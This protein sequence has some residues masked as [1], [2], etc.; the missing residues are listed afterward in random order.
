MKTAIEN[1]RRELHQVLELQ[2]TL[3]LQYVFEESQELGPEDI[4][5]RDLNQ[6]AYPQN[7]KLYHRILGALGALVAV[8]DTSANFP[9]IVNL[10][11]I[12]PKTNDLIN[13]QVCGGIDLGTTNSCVSVFRN[14]QLEVLHNLLNGTYE[15]GEAAVER[16]SIDS[17][18]TVYDIKRMLGKTY[19][20][21]VLISKYWSFK[22]VDS[23]EYE[24]EES[25]L[26][27]V[28]LF[29]NGKEHNYRQIFP[30]SKG[31]NKAAMKM[32]GLTALELISEP[33]AAAFA[34]GFDKRK[35]NVSAVEVIGSHFK[36]LGH[37]GDPNLGGRDFDNA[38]FNLCVTKLKETCN[39]DCFEGKN[40]Q[41][42]MQECESI[43]IALSDHEQFEIDLEH[44]LRAP[45]YH[46]KSVI[47]KRSEFEEASLLLALKALEPVDKLLNSCNLSTTD[48]NKVLLIGLSTNMP[49]IRRKLSKLFPGKLE[50]SMDP[51]E[52]VARGAALRAAQFSRQADK[53]YQGESPLA[54]QNLLI[55]K[56]EMVCKEKLG[57]AGTAII[58]RGDEHP[59]SFD[60]ND[61]PLRTTP[62]E[63]EHR[64][65]MAMQNKD[66]DEREYARQEAKSKFNTIIDQILHDI[67][68]HR[69]IYPAEK[70]KVN[71]ATSS[72]AVYRK[73]LKTHQWAT[74]QQYNSKMAEFS[75]EVKNPCSSE[76][77]D[78]PRDLIEYN[79]ASTYSDDEPTIDVKSEKSDSDDETLWLC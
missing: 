70:R 29:Y 40:K 9:I 42:L 33:C 56:V 17:D 35:Y 34:Y 11:Q 62:E 15:V 31:S 8:Y 46:G 79:G 28:K 69:P 1:K 73:W 66:R 72:C 27:K 14:G 5:L 24:V 47:I 7:L 43:K 45:E 22:L 13:F 3:E 19:K 26:P 23:Q 41:K 30:D 74:R 36:T 32:A 52:A 20:E 38:L 53:V 4:E 50:F 37:E 67:K 16:R 63:V 64:V 61:A 12:Q 76:E 51:S 21:L 6:M 25:F 58:I 48:I 71:Q 65:Q 57:K 54:D 10:K 75:E 59:K 44:L 77:E 49:L 60:L 39:E 18:N 2:R 68:K 55:K 78:D